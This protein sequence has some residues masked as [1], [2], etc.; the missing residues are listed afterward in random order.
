LQRY[1][2]I[3]SQKKTIPFAVK[4]IPTSRAAM[5]RLLDRFLLLALIGA[6]TAFAAIDVPNGYSLDD[7]SFDHLDVAIA[8]DEAGD[9]RMAIK[10]FAAAAK[11]APS[12]PE[13]FTNLAIA[14]QSVSDYMESAK[15]AMTALVLDPTNAQ[16]IDTL[17]ELK[18]GGNDPIRAARRE[19]KLEQVHLNLREELYA[20]D[21]G[22]PLS[23]RR[24]LARPFDE[25]NNRSAA[26]V[27]TDDP[28]F[29]PPYM[30]DA[31]EAPP[32][33]VNV[34]GLS[35]YYEVKTDLYP[36]CMRVWYYVRYFTSNPLLYSPLLSPSLPLFG[37][38][39]FIGSREFK[40]RYFEKYPVL[41]HTR[42]STTFATH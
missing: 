8:Y 35:G 39:Q 38:Y 22:M 7:S 10:S 9:M 20:S 34:V 1:A 28:S 40:E 31:A 16:A 26:D 21:Q 33:E 12:D 36:W 42:Y 11:F 5:C 32:K 13:S 17:E 41:I 37:Y 25:S 24:D 3:F 14:Y 6:P 23:F 27:F 30:N 29:W 19:L 4:Y 18:E 15:A 2:D